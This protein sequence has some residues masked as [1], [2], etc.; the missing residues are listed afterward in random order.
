M[1]KKR[2]ER[3]SRLEEIC[4]E[5]RANNFRAEDGEASRQ[6]H[7]SHIHHDVPV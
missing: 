6:R 2:N 7:D 5:K 3:N 1:T 4:V